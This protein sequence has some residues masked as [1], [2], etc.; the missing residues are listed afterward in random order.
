MENSF[1]SV[2]KPGVKTQPGRPSRTSSD[3]IVSRLRGERRDQ[4]RSWRD[5]RKFGAR[6]D[7]SPQLSLMT[8]VMTE[9]FAL[10]PLA[11]DCS[12]RT[13]MAWAN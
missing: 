1:I 5:S 12:R 11:S 4:K 10:V 8:H 3:I 13:D 2:E 9:G 6:R 7:G